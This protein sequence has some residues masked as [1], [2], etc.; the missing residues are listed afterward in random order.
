MR[1]IPIEAAATAM[2]TF[3]FLRVFSTTPFTSLDKQNQREL[4]NLN[5]HLTTYLN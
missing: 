1:G 2:E 4:F 5:A 3:V